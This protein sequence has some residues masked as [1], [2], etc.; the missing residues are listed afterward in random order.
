[1]ATLWF[2]LADKAQ[3][4]QAD[5]KAKAMRRELTPAEIAEV[6]KRLAVWKPVSR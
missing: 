1:M 3:V 4:P 6:A 5:V 2:S